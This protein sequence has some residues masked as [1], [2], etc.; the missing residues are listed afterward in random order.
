MQE[1]FHGVHTHDDSRGDRHEEVHS[2]QD[3]QGIGAHNSSSDRLLQKDTSQLTV[4][5]RQSPKTKVRSCVG[6]TSQDKFDGFDDLMDSYFADVVFLP[7][8][9]FIFVMFSIGFW[10]FEFIFH[11]EGCFKILM[12]LTVLITFVVVFFVGMGW[13]FFGVGGHFAPEDDGLEDEHPGDANNCHH[14]QP[15]LHALLELDIPKRFSF[16]WAD[17]QGQGD[18]LSDDGGSFGGIS[19]NNPGDGP[20]GDD[21]DAHVSEGTEEKDLLRQP[22]EEGINIVFPVD[23]VQKLQENTCIKHKIPKVI[24]VTPMMTANFIL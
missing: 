1:T 22:L 16:S 18:H 2:D 6:D 15:K 9:I 4:G 8:A 3:D 11:V 23:G 10:F 21:E 13:N 24:W 5:Q 14:Q 19:L 7:V 17:F 20:F 12:V